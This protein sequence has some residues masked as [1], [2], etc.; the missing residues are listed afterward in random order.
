[1]HIRLISMSVSVNRV[2]LE[3]FSIVPQQSEKCPVEGLG[4]WKEEE[5]SEVLL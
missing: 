4:V 2:D 3:Y 1:M 5:R